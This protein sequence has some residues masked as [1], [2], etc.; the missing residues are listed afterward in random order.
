[1]GYGVTCVPGIVSNARCNND[2]R[3]IGMADERDLTM[4]LD[5]LRPHLY[6]LCNAAT[7]TAEQPGSRRASSAAF[8]AGMGASERKGT[9]MKTIARFFDWL[10]AGIA[11]SERMR[12]EAYLAQAS[13]HCD[14]EYRIH[15]LEREPSLAGRWR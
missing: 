14:L 15:E 8:P 2:L 10:T 5:I 6:S 11:E 1:M 9:V 3:A 4:R 12:R 13:D 7:A